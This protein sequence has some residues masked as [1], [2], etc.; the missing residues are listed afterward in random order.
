MYNMSNPNPSP[1]LVGM[2]PDEVHVNLADF[3]VRTPERPLR[4]G[5]LV[6]RLRNSKPEL[7]CEEQYTEDDSMVY[8]VP[9]FEPPL[10]NLDI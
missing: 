1:P 4:V 6:I 3:V 10:H 9:Q 5:A 2:F 7:L 8:Q